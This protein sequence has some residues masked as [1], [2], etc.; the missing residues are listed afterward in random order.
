[1]NIYV[2]TAMNYFFLFLF[3]KKY[4]NDMPPR[5]F[6]YYLLAFS[7]WILSSQTLQGEYLKMGLNLPIFFYFAY[8]AWKKSRE[9]DEVLVEGRD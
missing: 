4:K 1:M 9:S 3:V 7:I 5:L 6:M 8:L 2:W